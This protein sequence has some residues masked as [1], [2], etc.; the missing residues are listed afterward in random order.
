[1]KAA[2][3]LVKSE[4]AGAWKVSNEFVIVELAPTALKALQPL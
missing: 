3:E 1:M 4:S 2:A